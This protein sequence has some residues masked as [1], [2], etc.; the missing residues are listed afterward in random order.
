LG[1]FNLHYPL[2]G[3]PAV[4]RIYAESEELVAIIEDFDLNNILP[5]STVTFEEAN[6][7]S[8]I[9]LCLVTIGLVDRVI[10]SEITQDLNYDSDHLL[11]STTLDITTQQLEKAS[12][13]NYKRLDVKKYTSALKDTLPP[14]RRPETKVALNNYI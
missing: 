6:W 14:L 3:G 10:S 8:T 2:W 13:R 12:R 7:R 9:N 5:V 4:R 1:D 11:I